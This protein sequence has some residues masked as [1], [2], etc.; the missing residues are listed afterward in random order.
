MNLTKTNKYDQNLSKHVFILCTLVS[1]LFGGLFYIFTTLNRKQVKFTSEQ[2][3]I[4]VY[5]TAAQTSG[6]YYF[7]NESLFSTE[8]QIEYPLTN[9][10][11]EIIDAKFN[12]ETIPYEKQDSNVIFSLTFP[13]REES[14]LEVQYG[15]N[16]EDEYEYILTS[17]QKWERELDRSEFTVNLYNNAEISA[18]SYELEKTAETQY[19]LT[20]TNFIPESNFT[21]EFR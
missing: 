7:K 11:F 16:I 20:K 2:I 13:A 12:G 21:L 15:E 4:D 10:E 19:S 18:S 5:D 1:L 8:I 6:T 17:T 14:M 9:E 3:T